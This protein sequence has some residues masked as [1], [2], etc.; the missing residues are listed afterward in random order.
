MKTLK[1]SIDKNK[2]YVVACSFGPDSMALLF[3]AIQE[4]LNIVVAHVNYRKREASVFEQKSLMEY[5][6]SNG[7]KCYVLD[8]LKAKPTGNFQDWAR[9]QR[10]EFF[11]K[12]CD[13]VSANAVL[14][15]HQ[16]DDVIETYLM[17]KN[18]KI[19]V[20]NP[21]ISRENIIFGVKI[22][23][24]LLAY[25]KKYL[26]AFDD[27]NGIPYSVD[28]SN[29]TDHYERNRIRHSVVEKLSE[30]ERKRILEEIRESQSNVSVEQN[31]FTKD[32]FLGLSY[33]QIIVF[34]DGFMTKVNEHRDLSKK[35]VDEIKKAFMAKTN[36][37]VDI[38]ASVRLELDYG[39]V[40]VVNLQKL[41]SYYFAFAKTL[42]NELFAVDFS[43]GLSDR[44]VKE[45]YESYI[46]RNCS[47]T[48]ELII[49]NY[50]KKCGRLFIDWKMPLFLR[51]V[52]PGIFSKDGKLLYVP[53]YRKTF[54]DE[55]SSK[56]V[57]KTEY[58]TQF[59]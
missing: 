48:D 49:R 47:K 39:E 24:P 26:K 36:H 50:S 44:G 11:K 22:I 17:Q 54:T 7:I 59:D 20:K 56:L 3:A 21:G 57:F 42:D 35:F 14:V 33:E 58:F 45:K 55:H 10:Y 9:R 5:C 4:N 28:E 1:L 51:E 40:C 30:E 53:R 27:E 38:T 46:I 18:K 15:A 16:E 43:S 34:L 19:F 37:F 41:K 23:R 8:L 25:S 31:S 29:L 52:W 32:E 12:V 2:K 13:E 6:E